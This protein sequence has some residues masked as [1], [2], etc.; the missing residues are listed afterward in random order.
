MDFMKTFNLEVQFLPPSQNYYLGIIK[1]SLKNT[2]VK[3]IVNSTLTLCKEGYVAFD[4]S[5]WE[6]LVK[7]LKQESNQ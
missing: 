6:C 3:S 1:E 2:R 4:K 5:D 7:R